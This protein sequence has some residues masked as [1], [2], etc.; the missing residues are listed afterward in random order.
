MKA[1]TLILLSLLQCALAHGQW[2]TGWS[3]QTQLALCLYLQ[4]DSLLL[5]SPL[6]SR[7]PI[8]VSEWN[9]RNDTL[10]IA[11]AS[12]GFK[13]TLAR[14]DSLWQGTWR[15]GLLREAIT[16][17]PSDTIFQLRR[18]QTP[19]YPYRFRE[20]T[21]VAD[22]VDSH[23]DS[24]HLEGTLALPQGDGPFPALLLVSGSGQQ[25]RDE[26]LFQHKPFLV[27]ADY[28]AA[29]GIATLRYDDRGVGASRGPLEK[30]TTL[31]F[32]ED[33]EAM[34]GVLLEHRL[35]DHRWTGIGGHSEGGA[36]APLVAARNRGA[37]FV[38]ML[39]GQGERGLEVLAQQNRDL[40]RA[41][42]VSLPLCEVRSRCMRRL[43]ELPA[44]SDLKAYQAIIQEYTEKLTP[45]Q[46][47]SI[48][49]KRGM[50]YTLKQQLEGVWMREF[51][52]IDPADYLPQVTVPLLALQG[53]K[54]CQVS[55]E[56]NLPAI[57]RLKP[58]AVCREFPG[59]N[60]LFQHCRTG[61]PDEYIQ[62][63]ET[64]APEA[65]DAISS[66]IKSLPR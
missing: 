58:D 21:L 39:A 30:A 15:Q 32:S 63:E 43:L 22:Y 3:R 16:F 61:S 36:I 56:R 10:R 59:L 25:N 66:F 1:R 34:F 49:L 2:W 19:P 55:A 46:A 40:F 42:G 4:G 50:A 51:L 47:D 6:Q 26:E 45:A 38:V 31:I 17:R 11:C 33:A 65:M 20:E 60:H 57:Q 53:G 5:Y 12:I 8:P 23:G 48:E 27:L 35:V 29:H 24:I 7:D 14:Q 64:F 28:L 18:P 54:D 52:R 44:G 37:A 13:A 62:I 9:L 41:R